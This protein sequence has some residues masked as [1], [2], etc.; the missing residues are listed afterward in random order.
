[1]WYVVNLNLFLCGIPNCRQGEGVGKAC[2]CVNSILSLS[3]SLLEWHSSLLW[4]I[5]SSCLLCSV[6]A[7]MPRICVCVCVCLSFSGS[8]CLFSGRVA[9]FSAADCN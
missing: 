7:E 3:L 9:Y 8:F 5:I 6:Q 2:V 1:M 4:G